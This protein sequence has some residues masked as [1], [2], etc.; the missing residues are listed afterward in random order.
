MSASS[1]VQTRFSTTDLTTSEWLIVK[2]DGDGNCSLATAATDKIIGAIQD[3][4]KG[5]STVVGIG[6]LAGREYKVKCGG[7]VESGDALT[8]DSASKA[9]ATTTDGNVVFG[10]ALEDGASGGV[11]R[12]QCAKSRLYIA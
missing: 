1:E 9:V 4:G 7:T 11:I 10:W 8:A 5:A 12:Y 6:E 3:V 2:D